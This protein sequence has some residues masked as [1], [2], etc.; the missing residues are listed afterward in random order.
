[1]NHVAVV[2]GGFAGAAAASAL[3][4]AGVSVTLLEQR[5]VLGGRASSLRD[6]KTGEDVDNGQHLFLGGYRDA[7]KFLSR[8]KVEDRVKFLPGFRLVFYAAAGGRTELSCPRLT[9]PWSFLAG[10]ARFRALKM[11]ERFSLL[12]GLAS[13]KLRKQRGLA[14]ITVAQWLDRLRQPAAARRAFWTPL[15]LAALN[16]RPEIACAEALAAVLREAFLDGSSD[17]RL[18][19]STVGLS[20]LW[21]AELKNYLKERGGNIAHGQAVAGFETKNGRVK[22]LVLEGG[23]R[24]DIDAVVSAVSLPAFLKICPEDLRG[25]YAHLRKVSFSAIL[26]VNLWFPAPLFDEAFAG[27]LDSDFQWA[28]HRSRL[29]RGTAASPGYVSL[30]MS[31]AQSPYSSMSQEAIAAAALKDLRR[32]F[33]GKVPEPLHASVLWEKR[34]TPS[35]SPENWG[36]RP[37]AATPLENFFLAGD[38][39]DTGLPATI[40]AACRSGHAAARAVRSF[41]DGAPRPLEETASC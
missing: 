15:C 37:P 40:E 34:A 6:G 36:R 7:R 20:R 18:G 16:E 5:P 21:A 19:Y 28:F 25:R 17:M 38:W 32:C 9:A 35:P 10:L 1:M 26:S 41:L 22:G 13:I 3:A 4:E 8:L 33:P 11:S 24:A 2:G 14:G 39:V 30:V 23:Q 31:G 29:W 12:R 27:L